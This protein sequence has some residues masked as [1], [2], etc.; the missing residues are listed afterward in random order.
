LWSN[1]GPAVVE[2]LDR[3]MQHAAEENVRSILAEARRQ[4]DE[5]LADLERQVSEHQAIFASKTKTLPQR[6]DAIAQHQTRQERISVEQLGRR[7][8]NN[9][10]FR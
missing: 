6:I 9:S 7:L 4:V 3:S 8:P 1:L 10:L 5:R 2:A